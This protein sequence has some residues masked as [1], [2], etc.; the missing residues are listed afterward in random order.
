MVRTYVTANLY[1]L[2]LV[3]EVETGLF[4]RYKTTATSTE[5]TATAI[6]ESPVVH[7]VRGKH[8]S[9]LRIIIVIVCCITEKITVLCTITGISIREETVRYALLHLQVKYGLLLAVINTCDT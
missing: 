7:I 1:F 8:K 4:W 3:C 5:A 2:V 9:I 6:G